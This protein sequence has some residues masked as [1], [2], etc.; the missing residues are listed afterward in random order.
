MSTQW[1]ALLH[2]N[3]APRRLPLVLCARHHERTFI[4][5]RR[6]GDHS[7]ARDTA[8]DPLVSLAHLGNGV[9][10]WVVAGTPLTLHVRR[11]PALLGFSW[12]LVPRALLVAGLRLCPF[13]VIPPPAQFSYPSPTEDCPPSFPD[14]GT[15]VS[16]YTD[17]ITERVIYE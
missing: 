15:R 13:L 4:P 12:T 2:P 9:L 16:H 17:W 3:E 1:L 6:T 11:P 7:V 10:L 14:W 5:P 8:G